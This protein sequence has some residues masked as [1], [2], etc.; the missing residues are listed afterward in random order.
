MVV[1]DDAEP[2]AEP[3]PDAEELEPP[4]MWKGKEYWSVVGAESSVISNPYVGNELVLGTDQVYF[5]RELEMPLAITAPFWRVD[6]VAPWRRV[7]V[8]GPVWVPA[9]QRISNEEPAGMFWS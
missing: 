1:V 2:V 3:E 7:M 5:P 4:V 6:G 9:C 8:I